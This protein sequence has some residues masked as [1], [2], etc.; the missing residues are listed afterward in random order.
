MVEDLVVVLRVSLA[1]DVRDEVHEVEQLLLVTGFRLR[2]C[3]G[4][5][6]I[7]IEMWTD[8]GSFTIGVILVHVGRGRWG[9]LSTCTRWSPE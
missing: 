9:P 4:T 8:M 7:A 6:F 1:H 5:I 2:I 3:L